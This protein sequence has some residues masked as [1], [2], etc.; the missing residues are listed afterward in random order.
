MKTYLDCFPC[1]INQAL[2]A[3]RIATTDEA[4][5]KRVMDEVG[6]MFR[7]ISLESPP[8]ATGRLVYQK[9][10]LITG[11]P[12]PYGQLKDLSTRN[13]LAL[14]PRLKALVGESENRLLMAVR[15]AIAGNVIDFGTNRA[16]DM[17]REVDTALTRDF[18]TCDYGPFEDAVA[19][20]NEILY[21]GDNAGECVFDKILI[22]ALNRPVTY[23]VRGAPIINDATLRDARQAG[24]D[25]VATLISSGTDA[26]GTILETC[27]EAFT[28]IYNQAELIISKGQGNYEALSGQEKEIFFL[29]KT[30]CPVVARNM[31]TEE[32][33]LVL[34]ANP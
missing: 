34:K 4:K 33:D 21:I 20:A 1:F 9:V 18:D 28:S 31:G 22:E 10:H 6:A 3:A 16:F 11:N 2:R 13:A 7:E 5:I 12:D 14:Y 25:R 17:E 26:P 15:I 32:G 19:K 23:V 8:P 30:K 27:D 29:L 24:L